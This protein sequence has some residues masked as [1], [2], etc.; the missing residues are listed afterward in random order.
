MPGEA[1]GECQARRMVNARRGE[2]WSQRVTLIH[3]EG[4]TSSWCR[5]GVLFPVKLSLNVI[6]GDCARRRTQLASQLA[7]LYFN[8]ISFYNHL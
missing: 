1:N 2:W 3:P 5:I 8:Q 7:G 6:C 4:P